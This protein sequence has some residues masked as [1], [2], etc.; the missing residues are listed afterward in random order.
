MIFFIFLLDQISF[1]LQ[2]FFSSEI[3][4][5]VAVDILEELTMGL[6]TK[7]KRVE[8][9]T[10]NENLIKI[11]ATTKNNISKYSSSSEEITKRVHSLED[12][13]DI[14]RYLETNA[15]IITLVSLVLGLLVHRYF[16]ILTFIVPTFLLQHALQGWCPPLP[17]F[18]KFGKRTK[19]EIDIERHA[20]KALRGDYKRAIDP[21]HA[22]KSAKLSD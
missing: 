12:E 1:Y 6:L 3:G 16:F 17:I 8:R 10:S 5:D 19:R 15:S 7:G 9:H 21:Y 20:L 18:R 2:A 4:P 11:E 13:W 22:Y 14:E